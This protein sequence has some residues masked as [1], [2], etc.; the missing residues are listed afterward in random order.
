MQIEYVTGVCFTSRRTTEQKGHSTICYGMLRKVI[1]NNEDIFTLM[2]EIF[3][4][5]YTGIRC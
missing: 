1:I 4:N 5:R 3:C 2:H